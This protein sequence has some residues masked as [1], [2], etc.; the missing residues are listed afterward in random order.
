ME[1]QLKI[2]LTDEQYNELMTT[3]YEKLFESDDFTKAL[4]D[5]I[6]NAMADFVAKNPDIIRACLYKEKESGYYGSRG[7][8]YDAT[9]TAKVAISKASEDSIKRLEGVCSDI[10]NR[11]VADDD[12][13]SKI[14]GEILK[15]AML[16]GMTDGIRDYIQANE[17]SKTVIT[18]Y[19]N[20]T[21]QH[22]GLE[23]NVCI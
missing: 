23:N 21:R 14:F 19:L 18:S 2:D 22:I 3:S 8:Y 10:I 12:T 13:F 17:M 7:R 16:D 4:G 1:I 11:I 15:K 20:E 5:I 6:V 9:E